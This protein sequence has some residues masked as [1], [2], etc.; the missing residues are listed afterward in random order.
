MN[1]ELEWLEELEELQG[2]EL[3][4]ELEDLGKLEALEDLEDLGE[5]TVSDSVAN[6]ANCNFFG[7]K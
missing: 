4:E 7:E 3:L 6:A 5:P 1:W 2:L